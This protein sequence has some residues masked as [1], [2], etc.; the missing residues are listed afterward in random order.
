MYWTL[1]DSGWSW[2]NY[3]C[4]FYGIGFKAMAICNETSEFNFVQLPFLPFAFECNAW[5]S[6]LFEYFELYETN[7]ENA[8]RKCWTAT[9]LPRM[10]EIAGLE[11]N[12][13]NMETAI[14]FYN[15]SAFVGLELWTVQF[16]K[17]QECDL[18]VASRQ[19]HVLIFEAI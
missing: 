10:E 1:I 3:H 2:N 16:Q 15:P 8:V 9:I 12:D 14:T 17:C 11:V 19:F 4:L 13:S 7:L 18:N 5:H 6:E